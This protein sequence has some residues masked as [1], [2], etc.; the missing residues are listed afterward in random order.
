MFENLSQQLWRTFLGAVVIV[1][2]LAFIVSDPMGGQQGCQP[3]GETH[4]ARVYGK[5]ITTGDFQAAY[6][7]A[8][9]I[10]N[11]GRSFQMTR[12]NA[13][14]FDLR[15]HVM[16]GLVERGL[17]AKKARELGF[18]VSQEDV[19]QELFENGTV[20]YTAA[21][22]APF[23]LMSGPFPLP[24]RDEDGEFDREIAEN[25]I[26]YQLRRSL[27]EFAENQIEDRLAARMR[28]TVV[29]SVAVS[30]Q[31]TWDAYVQEKDQA[32]ISFIQVFPR[33][34]QERLEPTE[35]EVRAW[36]A[37]EANQEAV[38][39]LYE[40]RQREFT[41]LER[42]V[43][44]RHILVRMEQGATEEVERQ[45]RTRAE[46]IL[47]KVREGSESFGALARR[48]SDGDKAARGGDLG[49]RAQGSD[50]PA[51]VDEVMFSLE[52]GSVSDIV[53]SDFG[54]HIVLVE[55]SREGTVPEDEALLDIA[56]AEYRSARGSEIARAA[57]ERAR[58]LLAEGVEPSE[59]AERLEAFPDDPAPE[60]DEV[61]PLAA[62]RERDSNAP[63]GRTSRRFGRGGVPIDGVDNGRLIQ[64]VFE[65]LTLESPL[66]D[67]VLQ[68]GRDFVA[69]KLTEREHATEEGFTDAIRLRLT[70]GLRRQK[71]REALTLYLAQL[72]DEA[73]RAGAI[74][75]NARMLSYDPNAEPVPEE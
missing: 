65:D 2:A 20:Y 29:A 6:T 70:E 61:D 9:F 73:T 39:R 11:R 33:Y 25:L 27:G 56:T 5:S 58:E 37:E 62:D 69:F 4:A 41:D 63:L 52:P 53:R 42:Q 10:L 72:R 8:S 7:M 21:V 71:Q 15:E 68:M 55:Q 28:D 22:D 26:Q 44:A 47:A 14:R 67:E 43:R 12:T 40:A 59:I 51:P 30:P 60:S 34:Y 66:P 32:V 46:A 49:W 64:I 57:A 50:V 31:E 75:V 24:V 45:A 23:Q 35:D 16:N 74:D 3:P 18:E 38:Q 17:L 54:F 36:M 19:W 48:Y 13:E 1:L